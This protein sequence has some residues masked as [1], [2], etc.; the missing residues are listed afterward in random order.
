MSDLAKFHVFE[1]ENSSFFETS[2]HQPTHFHPPRG[3][4]WEGENPAFFLVALFFSCFAKLEKEWKMT[5]CEEEENKKKLQFVIIEEFWRFVSTSPACV[6]ITTNKPTG[7]PIFD[8][9]NI[10][11]NCRFSHTVVSVELH[12][13]DY[14]NLQLVEP[15]LRRAYLETLML[16]EFLESL[17]YDIYLENKRR[18]EIIFAT[19]RASRC[20]REYLTKHCEYNYTPI[21]NSNNFKCASMTDIEYNYTP[22][23]R[24]IIDNYASVV[25]KI[26]NKYT[27]EYL[28]F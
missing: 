25:D 12:I 19:K 23:N 24:K 21:N 22:T 15:F 4:R 26:I 27:E 28:R 13:P 20:S 11:T 17:K 7:S 8:L 14:Q 1:R 18:K 5:V 3:N 6:L 2:P 16:E 9:L 10:Y